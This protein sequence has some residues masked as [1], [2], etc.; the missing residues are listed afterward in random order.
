MKEHYNLPPKAIFH[1]LL[2]DN[3]I[4]LDGKN[5]FTSLGSII[6]MPWGKNQTVNCIVNSISPTIY[7]GRSKAEL[8][9]EQSIEN[10]VD[11]E[12][13]NFTHENRVTNFLVMR[14][15]ASNIDSL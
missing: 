13:Y 15:S 7:E 1:A 2:G 12:Y 10:M 5:A 6:K 9:F 14:N 11:D 8:Q 3:S 4:I